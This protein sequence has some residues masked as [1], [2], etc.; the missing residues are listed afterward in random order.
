MTLR[1]KKCVRIKM[2][3]DMAAGIVKIECLQMLS[4]FEQCSTIINVLVKTKA[5]QACPGLNLER[6]RLAQ[7]ST[8]AKAIHANATHKTFCNIRL[9]RC[10]AHLCHL[11]HMFAV[12]VSPSSMVD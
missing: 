7:S 11:T 2:K 5:R 12:T 9:R 6:Q 4:T 8:R 10:A 3:A 1:N